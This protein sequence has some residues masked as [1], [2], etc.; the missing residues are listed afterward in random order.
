VWGCPSAVASAVEGT[1]SS[2]GVMCWEASR[3]KCRL[4]AATSW[5][6]VEVS[7]DKNPIVFPRKVA[8]ALRHRVLLE[9]IILK[10]AI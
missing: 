10:I 3:G 1:T 6:S 7:P 5:S 2:G 9:D 4:R 8:A